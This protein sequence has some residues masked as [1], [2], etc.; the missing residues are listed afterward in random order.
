MA[1]NMKTTNLMTEKITIRTI[2]VN[3]E[4]ASS[5]QW[6]GRLQP[7]YEQLDNTTFEMKHQ[8]ANEYSQCKYRQD[9]TYHMYENNEQ[10]IRDVLEER[11]INYLES[12]L[13]IQH[14]SK[15]PSIRHYKIGIGLLAAICVILLVILIAV[16]VI[17]SASMTNHFLI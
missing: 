7:Y 5:V 10:S 12:K 13:P 15:E 8:K 17:L 9:P 3:T 2:Y 6:E 11:E 1:L 4:D 16:A 14:S